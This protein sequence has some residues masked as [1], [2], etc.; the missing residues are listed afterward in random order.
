MIAWA[1]KKT[2]TQYNFN[3]FKS[4]LISGFIVSLV[5]LPLAMALS[6]A[7][8]LSPQYGLYTAIVA[9]I[10]VPLLGGS[11]HQV[12]GPTAAFVVIIAPIVTL[13]GLRGLILTTIIAGII[14][15]IAGIMK[16][17]RYIR[18]IPYPVTTGFTSGI[19]IIIA[20]LSLNDFLGLHIPKMPDHFFEKIILIT[21]SM[22]SKGIQF[23]ELA[24]GIMTLISIKISKHINKHLPAPI[25][26]IL[27][28][29]LI[30]LLFIHNG[31]A[32]DTIG[33]RFQYTLP[34]GKIGHGVPP[35]MPT[36]NFFG[37]SGSNLF[38]IPSLQELKILTIPAIIVAA[39]AA[40]ESV[41]SA[42][43]ADV[44][45]K[46]KHQPNAELI[47]I[48]IGN[49]LTGLASGIPATGAIART[50]TNIQSGGK[51]P[52]ASMFH[53]FF[54]LGY[55]LFF[56]NLI[57]YLPMSSLAALLLVT[58]Y[59]MSRAQ[60]FIRILKIGPTED[61]IALILCF[62]FTVC[63]DMVAGITIGVITACFLLI[64]RV[65]RMTE[66]K[67]SAQGINDHTQNIHYTLPSDTM[68]YHINGSVFFGN[69][70]TILEQIEFMP[71]H[72]HKLVFDLTEVPFID[73]TGMITLK[74]ILTDLCAH[75]KDVILCAPK[76]ILDQIKKKMHSSNLNIQ[77][78]NNL[79]ASL[80]NIRNRSSHG[81]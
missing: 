34:N 60:Q 18:Y 66:L 56:S 3:K 4:D 45:A 43:V 57:S 35:F 20:I 55:V 15:I 37:F 81:I 65:A 44:M 33:T 59:H 41:L 46:T 71:P 6:I 17:G 26:G 7:V 9:G 19:A 39:L 42:A 8:G 32:I 47:G 70:E 27:I 73:M 50:A 49:I 25:V 10:T 61:S 58:A 1:L 12:S 78:E 16:I 52:L 48:G 77:F 53:A 30:S 36:F 21:H 72:I 79:K 74:R 38:K 24:I 63:I 29:T 51:T 40:L 67:I 76:T 62:L 23:P 22:L 14:L 28:G 31:I 2:I 80:Q 64:K 75:K 13:H 54:I 68:I 5:A 69:V 11:I